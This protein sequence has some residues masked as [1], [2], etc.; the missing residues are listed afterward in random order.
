ML[1][2]SHT[3]ADGTQLHGTARGDGSAEV[4]RTRPGGSYWK[5]SRHLGAW[6]ILRSRDHLPNHHRIE[7]TAQALRAAG[8]EVTTEV[9]DASRPTS[10]VVAEQRARAADRAEALDEKVGRRV[11]EA[12][13]HH[14]GARRIYN[15]YPM[16]QPILIGHHSEGRH[17]RDLER[18]HRHDEKSWEAAAQARYAAQRAEAARRAASGREARSTVEN[19]VKKLRADIARDLRSLHGYWNRWGQTQTWVWDEG[20][21]RH[22]LQPVPVEP[23]STY[24]QELITRIVENT[25]QR[26][27]WAAVLEQMPAPAKPAKPA[28]GD[29]VEVDAAWLPVVRS[30]KH[31]VTVAWPSDEDPKRTRRV[32]WGRISA[33]TR[34][35]GAVSAVPPRHDTPVLADG[36]DL[37]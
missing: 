24:G 6:F 10:D 29:T 27:Y 23:D 20:L 4:L 5:W 37:R 35:N 30:S 32:P 19:R 31:D 33:W 17:R 7:A 2:L 21:G 12:E 34:S 18:A 36:T 22:V 8:F 11:G 15:G 9:D 28:K 3:H 14:A 26:L 13:A 1:T 25:D 16:G